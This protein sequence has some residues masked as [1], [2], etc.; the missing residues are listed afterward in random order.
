MFTK[1]KLNTLSH[2]FIHRFC[3][4]SREYIS[5]YSCV[6]SCARVRV[7]VIADGLLY[8]CDAGTH[9]IE[10]MDTNGQHRNVVFSDLGAHFFGLAAS[11]HHIYYSDWKRS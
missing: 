10:S 9:L 4:N 7:Y 8:F 3:H 1:V 6:R 11:R 2:L 5:I